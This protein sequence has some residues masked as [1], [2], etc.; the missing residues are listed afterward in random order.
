MGCHFPPPGDLPDPGI[1]PEFLSSP[2][3]A[4]GSFTAEPL[5][6]PRTI[7]NYSLYALMHAQSLSCVQL[8]ATPQ[9]TILCPWDSPGKNTGVGCHSL[10]QWIFPTQGSNP[11]VLLGRPVLYHCATWEAPQPLCVCAQSLFAT[12]WTMT[13]Q[14][15]LCMGFSRQEYWSGL[16]CPPLGHLPNPGVK[17]GSPTL[18]ADSLP[19]EPPGKSKN[20]GVGSLSLLQGIFPTQ[21]LNRGLLNCREILFELSYQGR[22]HSLCMLSNEKHFMNKHKSW[23]VCFYFIYLYC[24]EEALFCQLVKFFQQQEEPINSVALLTVTIF[25]DPKPTM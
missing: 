5:G 6:Q 4:S 21:E 25:Q 24:I 11:S 23:G 17:P 22:P 20:T 7:R 15:P 18:Q 2:A 3:S 1:E 9:R 8:F 13:L 14:A 10:L 16:P 19:S 12:P